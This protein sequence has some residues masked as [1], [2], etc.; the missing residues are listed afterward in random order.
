[1]AD[2]YQQQWG[3][4]VA[5]LSAEV[6]RLPA[7]ERRWMTARL[8]RIGRLQRRLHRLFLMA[9]GPELC[10][11]CQGGCCDCGRNHLTLVNLLPFLLAEQAPPAADFSRICPFVGAQGC[12]LEPSRRP[13]NCVI[14]LC[15]TVDSALS[16]GQR[17]LFSALERRLRTL[18]LEFDQRYAGSSLRG[19]FIRHQTLCGAPFLCPPAKPSVAAG[20]LP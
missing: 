16:A 15:D 1:M 4:I 17:Q 8:A 6:A 13:Y 9:D 7:L 3:A 11:R 10:R 5:G 12:L 18:Y 19:I 20:A 2:N 14:F